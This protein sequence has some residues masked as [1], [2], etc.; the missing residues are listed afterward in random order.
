MSERSEEIGVSCRSGGSS[1]GAGFY[2]SGLCPPLPFIGELKRIVDSVF[3]PESSPG[4]RFFNGRPGTHGAIF[5]F[6]LESAD[7]HR[8]FGW[9]DRRTRFHGTFHYCET[10][11]VRQSCMIRLITFRFA[12]EVSG[13]GAV[14]FE[15]ERYLG[16]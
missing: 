7:G 1:H 4:T 13:N 6:C 14:A 5:S 2:A 12:C 10:I 16:Y 9:P 11:I 8:G 15:T 3:R